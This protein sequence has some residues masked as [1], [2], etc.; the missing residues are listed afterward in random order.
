MQVRKVNS[1]DYDVIIPLID[2]WWAG[3]KMSDKLPR[4]FFSHF[5]NTSF[6]FE[7]QGE[8]IGFLIGFLSQEKE[9]EAYIHFVG[10]HPNYRKMK[11]ARQLYF[12]FFS[13]AKQHGRDTIR[14]ITSPVNKGS[15]EYHTKMGFDIEESNFVVD[16]VS[17]FLE[18][19]GP[20]QPRV[21][22]VKKLKDL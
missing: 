9:N 4:L 10:V 8:I 14:C 5:S 16:G 15:I 6:V 7:K 2:E 22:F 1:S 18:Y 17:V 3:R 12:E 21:L 11:I 19:D 13:K 20:E